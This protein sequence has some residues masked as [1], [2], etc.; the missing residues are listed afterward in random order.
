MQCTSVDLNHVKGFPREHEQLLQFARR[1]KSSCYVL[2][3]LIT[4]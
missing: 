3:N 1:L 4:I 2:I